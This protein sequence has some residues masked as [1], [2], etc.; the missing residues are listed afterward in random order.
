MFLAVNILL[1]LVVAALAFIAALRGRV[2]FNEGARNG[3]LEFFR[4]LPRIFTPRA[5]ELF[6]SNCLS[7]ERVL[8]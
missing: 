8:R 6:S 2:L 7:M 1:W 5:T 4:L 3:A